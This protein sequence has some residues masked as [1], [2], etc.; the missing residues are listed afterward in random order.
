MNWIAEIATLGKPFVPKKHG[1]KSEEA[2]G[3]GEGQGTNGCKSDLLRKAGGLSERS[4]AAFYASSF[5]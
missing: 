1:S 4:C 3:I 2:G 5:R